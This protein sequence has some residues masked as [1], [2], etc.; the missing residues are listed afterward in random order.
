MRRTL[1]VAALGLLCSSCAFMNRRNLPVMNFCRERL[2]PENRTARLALAPVTLPLCAAAGVLD[3]ALVHPA[4]VVGDAWLDTEQ[5]LWRSSGRGYVTECALFPV[6]AGLTPA[7]WLIQF[8]SRAVFD[9]P[10]YPPSPGRLRERLLSKNRQR[11]MWTIMPLARWSYEGEAVAPA[12]EAMLEAC[13][14]YAKDVDFC[15]EVIRRLPRPLTEN[16]AKYLMTQARAGRGYLCQVS[17]WRLFVECLSPPQGKGGGQAQA[18]QDINRLAG[19]YE[20]LVKAGHHEAEVYIADLTARKASVPAAW[21]LALYITRS[22]ARR[23]W[24]DYSEAAAFRIQMQLFRNTNI[25]R[26]DAVT[27]EW[28][29]LRLKW[30]W[31]AAV[32]DAIRRQ[33]AGKGSLKAALTRKQNEIA[34]RLRE[35]RSDQAAQLFYLAEVLVHVKT[36]LDAEEMAERLL[37]GPRADLELFTGS[38]LELLKKK[39]GS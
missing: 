30:G 28:R 7:V 10:P 34:S 3:A 21:A 2:V 6:R 23:G 27:Y 36:L 16:A 17:I 9:R 15:A 4:S 38:P 31:L 19:L 39:G 37:K 13:R 18:E 25:A 29:A 22:L 26:I 33:A 32:R 5:L 14:V 35:A 12:T 20:E 8:A 24:P 1:L 11:R